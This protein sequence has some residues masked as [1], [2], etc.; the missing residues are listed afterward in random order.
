MTA[1]APRV[2]ESRR[3]S[4]AI[5][6]LRR[7]LRS[8][9]TLPSPSAGLPIDALYYGLTTTL[10]ALLA[11]FVAVLLEL[12]RPSSAMAT[13]LIVSS[14]VRGM[15]LS[16]SLYRMIG[17]FVGGG[18]ALVLVDALGQYS[19]L[20]FLALALWI[21]ACTAVATLFRNFRAYGA[22][23][24]GYTVAMIGVAAIQTPER[25]FDIAIARVAVVTVG[26][27]CAGLVSGILSPGA[28]SRDL[29]PRLRDAILLALQLG[30][31]ALE[32]PPVGV[33]ERR[34]VEATGR[35]L[36][37]NDLAEFA[38]AESPRAARRANAIRSA[39]TAMIAAVTVLPA[40]ADAA[41][42]G[43]AE[44]PELIPDLQRSL[45]S[46][47]ARLRDAGSA[48]GEC[49][50]DA[51]ER[52]ARAA[53]A[54][55]QGEPS[56]RAL[57]LIDNL[58]ELVEQLDAALVDLNAFVENR[59]A[60]TIVSIGYHRDVWGALRNGFRAFLGILGAGTFCYWVGWSDGGDMIVIMAVC[61]SLLATTPDPFKASFNHAIGVCIGVV[62]A[63]L[64][65]FL[66]LTGT[67]GGAAELALAV[68]PPL[69]A[70]FLITD[71]RF[72]GVAGAARLFFA[73][74]LAPTNPMTFDLAST[75]NSALATIVG[76]VFATY[77]YR[78]VL[79]LNP[80]K[81]VARLI[82]AVGAEI[83]SIRTGPIGGRALT[84]SRIYHQLVQLTTRLDP[85]RPENKTMIAK[86]FTETRAALALQRARTALASPGVSQDA[87]SLLEGAIAEGASHRALSETASALAAAAHGAA[88]P[89]RQDLIRASAAL[90]EAAALADASDERLLAA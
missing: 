48:P 81:E 10:G 75:L 37:L 21:A 85:A 20:F 9:G 17:T 1:C 12:D 82:G 15:V 36:A 79:P 14:P 19:E 38:A 56:L 42:E 71:P 55:E 89:A 11:L 68:A 47:A 69:I 43:L 25:A 86:A 74:T 8:I 26:V 73:V 78:V 40:I 46:V 50:S 35:I 3:P 64:C 45:D 66:L 6:A 39:I 84:E 58:D 5:G 24:S 49:L 90:A 34:Y 72:A 31:E 65:K 54:V 87:R 57:Q 22:I 28:A 67:D 61:C 53:E 63:V 13:V 41:P 33:S 52:L 7:T 70:S 83:E 4:G 18:V 29:A 51:R 59:P 16:K 44:D 2:D 32:R 88:L 77:L 23:L 30:R 80:K 62:V 60:R 27:V 76:A